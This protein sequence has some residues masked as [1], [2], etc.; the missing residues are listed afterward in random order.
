MMLCAALMD[1]RMQPEYLSLL[2]NPIPPSVNNLKFWIEEAWKSGEY[3]YY[4]DMLRL[5]FDPLTSGFDPEGAQ[6]L[7][8]KLV[9]H[10]KWIGTAGKNIAKCLSIC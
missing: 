6:E 4:S 8:C 10:K 5:A 1:Q 9:D 7:K 3:L 2:S